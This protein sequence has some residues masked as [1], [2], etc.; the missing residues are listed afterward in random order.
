M[1]KY[2]TYFSI[3]KYLHGFFGNFM[4]ESTSIYQRAQIK[5]ACRFCINSYFCHNIFQVTN[6]NTIKS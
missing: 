4:A 6:T 2:R 5:G 3:S 1:V